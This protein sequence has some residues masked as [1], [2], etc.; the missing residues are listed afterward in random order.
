MLKVTKSFNSE[1]ARVC[2]FGHSGYVGI[3]TSVEIGGMPFLE[4]KYPDVY[5]GKALH[6][7]KT[8]Y[9]G[10]NAIFS[11][12]PITADEYADHYN[13]KPELDDLPF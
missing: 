5:D 13:P 11:I 8:K 7:I 2:L 3:I 1:Y 6:D 9:F 10:Q 4:V 12:E